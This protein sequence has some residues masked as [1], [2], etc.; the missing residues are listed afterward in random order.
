[1]SISDQSMRYYAAVLNPQ[2]QQHGRCIAAYS[3]ATKQQSSA[4]AATV[5][6]MRTN[7]SSV[8]L[9][10][11]E[12]QYLGEFISVWRIEL[13]L[14]MLSSSPIVSSLSPRNTLFR[15]FLSPEYCLFS[16][17]SS[18][19]CP[20]PTAHSHTLPRIT[21]TLPSL[22]FYLSIYVW[23]VST[24]LPLLLLLL[25]LTLFCRLRLIPSWSTSN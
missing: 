23:H 6:K 16:H 3:A 20:F 18:Y 11:E 19:Y 8:N 14:R 12:S 13:V 5:N 24:L 10:S 15:T 17:L 4:S 25:L 1:M 22:P 7:P 9:G 2:L 21:T